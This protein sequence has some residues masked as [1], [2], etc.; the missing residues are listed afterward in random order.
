MQT[1]TPSACV[2]MSHMC[3]KEDSFGLKCHI[4]QLAYF[5]PSADTIVV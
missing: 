2:L 4:Y 5:D 3:G 1:P